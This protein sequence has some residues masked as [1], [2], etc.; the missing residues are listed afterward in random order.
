MMNYRAEKRS[1]AGWSTRIGCVAALLG[2]ILATGA[3]AQTGKKVTVGF[4]QIG[5]ESGWRTVNTDSIKSE[6]EKRG[7]NLKFADV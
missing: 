3:N 6:A 5:A 2:C 1:L 7:I 4:S